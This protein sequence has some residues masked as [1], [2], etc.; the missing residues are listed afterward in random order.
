M[1]STGACL[2]ID[3]PRN[4]THQQTTATENF[5]LVRNII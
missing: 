3:N 5:K 4:L 1:P 2:F